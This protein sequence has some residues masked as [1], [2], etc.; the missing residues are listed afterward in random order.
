[1]AR[2]SSGVLIIGPNGTGKELIAR[3]IHAHSNRAEKPFIP[4]D[5]TSFVSEL[6]PSHMFG[7]VR[8]AFT[9][10]QYD[11]LGCFRAADGG[12][13]FLD[14]IGELE[15]HLQAKLLARS[16]RRRLSPSAPRIRSPWTSGSSPPPIV[17]CTKTYAQGGSVRILYYRLNIVELKTFPLKDRPEDIEPLA[18]H[19]MTVLCKE[20]GLL[21]TKIE[22]AAVGV[23]RNF[24]WPGNVRE[25][26][27][28]LER[29]LL[30]NEGGVLTPESLRLLLD[31][32]RSDDNCSDD[33]RSDDNRS[34]D[35]R[36]DDNRS[37]DNRSDDNRSDDNPATAGGRLSAD[38]LVDVSRTSQQAVD[39]A[40]SACQGGPGGEQKWLSLADLDR[41]Y[42]QETLEH[43]L[44]N[45][46]RAARLL[47]VTPRVLSRLIKKHGIDLCGSHRGRPSKDRSS[48]R[49]RPS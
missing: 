37:D 7:H 25:L 46:T 13:V 35:N 21:A 17:S 4:V 2:F 49:R 14:E 11:A 44:Q 9:G 36:S 24:N 6:F 31:D 1:M 8:G 22:A 3:S 47:G 10:A 34:D 42:I 48:W 16:K 12:T 28:V 43:T 15:F 20:N 19:F 18:G 30:F 23:L 5:C 38:A 41:Y 40:A 27:N 39:Q 45:R 33:N 32:N 26:R 29:A